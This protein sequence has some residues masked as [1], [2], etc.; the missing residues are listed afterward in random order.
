MEFEESKA[1]VLNSEEGSLLE[2]YDGSSQGSDD[3]LDSSQCNLLMQLTSQLRKS[4]K[5]CRE[6]SKPKI[7]VVH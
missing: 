2:S 5:Q 7:K 4:N 6:P 3:N 1:S